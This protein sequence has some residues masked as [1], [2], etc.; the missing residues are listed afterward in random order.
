M[1]EFLNLA[2]E[3][4]SQIIYYLTEWLVGIVTGFLKVFVTGVPVYAAIFTSYFP[5][6]NL[7]SKVLAVLLVLI[8]IA[9]PCLLAVILVRKLILYIRLKDTKED[10][11]ELYKEIGRLNRQVLNLMDEKNKILALKVN[12][13]GL[14]RVSYV[15]SSGLMDDV[16]VSQVV[17]EGNVSADAGIAG[18]GGANVGFNMNEDS[19]ANIAGGM[20][21]ATVAARKQSEEEEKK[22]AVRFPKL[23]LIDRK[24]MH[25]VE[26]KFDDEITL[27]RFCEGYRN[28]ASSQMHLYYTMEIVRRFV[29]GMASSHIMILEGISGTGKTSLPYSFSRYLAN[30]A[31][32]VSVQPNFRDRTELLGYFNE[33][34]KRFNETE[35]LRALYEA[36]YRDEPCLIVLDEMNLAR[37]EYYFA[38]MLSVLEMPSKDEWIVDLVPTGWQ[39][40]PVKLIDG[41]IRI[42]PNI[43][44]VGT[45]NNDDSTFTITDKVYDRAMPIE[46]NERAAA[47]EAQDQPAVHVTAEHLSDMFDKAK[48]MY[49]LSDGMQEKLNKLDSYLQTRF[50]LAIGN[51]I[52]KQM[53]DFVPVY[54]ATGGTEQDAIDYILSRKVLKKFE[55]LNLSFVRDEIKGLIAYIEKVFGKTG[56]KDSKDYLTRIQNLY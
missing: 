21:A 19:V 26:P 17:S 55:S 18:A 14:N 32:I 16:P 10:N 36:N 31:T 48:E 39:G 33:F 30:P 23:D 12:N 42:N 56:M 27:E 15:G 25:Y 43:W 6:L 37:I 50:K 24:Y 51:R 3:L 1:S 34:S 4:I 29:A 45:A 28:F 35:F 13:T 54:V 52:I 40:D 38:E 46:L 44:F 49:P 20:A 7:F 2:F 53:N 41:K 22:S 9:I 47:F 5:T 11:V 8:L